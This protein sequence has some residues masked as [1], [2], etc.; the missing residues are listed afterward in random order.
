M[1]FRHNRT[2]RHLDFDSVTYI[3][4]STDGCETWG[5]PQMLRF[6]KGQ[7]NQDPVLNVLSDGTIL[8]T[9]FVWRKESPNDR[10]NAYS[11]VSRDHGGSWE[12]PYF[13]A[14][15]TILCYIQIQPKKR[16]YNIHCQRL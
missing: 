6:Q 3:V 11:Y 4:K 16:K 14:V 13:I 12:G 15:L 7:G 2:N 5:K 8:M 1:A 9:V 10:Y